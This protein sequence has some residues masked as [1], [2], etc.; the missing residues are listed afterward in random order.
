MVGRRSVYGRAAQSETRGPRHDL[1]C[2]LVA[3]DAM[4]AIAAGVMWNIR[5]GTWAATV[6]WIRFMFA[7]A[8]GIR[9]RRRIQGRLLAKIGN[10]SGRNGGFV[11]VLPRLVVVAVVGRSRVVMM[12]ANLIVFSC[13]CLLFI[14]VVIAARAA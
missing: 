8:G 9:L 5:R 4:L 1:R 12:R 11:I 14:L 3:A 6:S 10:N 7:V 2:A 13:C